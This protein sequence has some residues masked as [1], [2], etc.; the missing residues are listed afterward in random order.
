MPQNGII[1][2]VLCGF[3]DAEA[4]LGEKLRV[5]VLN[6]L[7][8]GFEIIGKKADGDLSGVRNLLDFGLFVAFVIE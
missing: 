5:N 7:I 1:Q 3:G 8:L 2:T 6:N 4:D